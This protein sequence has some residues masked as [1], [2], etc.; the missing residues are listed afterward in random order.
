[1]I[2]MNAFLRSSQ[3]IL[4]ACVAVELLIGRKRSFAAAP[5]FARTGPLRKYSTLKNCQRAN[6]HR[7]ALEPD[8]LSLTRFGAA[9]ESLNPRLTKSWSAFR[10]ARL[11]QPKP[12][13]PWNVTLDRRPRFVPMDHGDMTQ[14]SVLRTVATA[15]QRPSPD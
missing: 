7:R 2:E 14:Y 1:M 6:E 15:V 12:I 5:K 11:G 8:R 4:G 10:L 9:S 3:G 13:A